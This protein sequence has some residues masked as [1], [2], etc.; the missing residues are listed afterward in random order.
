MLSSSARFFRRAVVKAEWYA[1]ELFP[2]VGFLQVD[3]FSC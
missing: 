2:H 3:T 1:G